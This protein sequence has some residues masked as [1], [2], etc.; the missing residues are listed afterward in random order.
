MPK[1]KREEGE[2]VEQAEETAVLTQR[3]Y[4]DLFWKLPS[5]DAIERVGA[6][7][8]VSNLLLYFFSY[9]LFFNVAS[10]SIEVA[11]HLLTFDVLFYVAS[12]LLAGTAE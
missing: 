5:N 4:L 3:E 1:R 7:E 6:S 9:N 2:K 12:R 11:L 8:Q 10:R